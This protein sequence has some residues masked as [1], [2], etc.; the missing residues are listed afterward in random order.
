M[1]TLRFPF[2]LPPGREIQVGEISSSVDGLTFVLEKREPFYVFTIRGF[3]SED[4]AK[5]YINNV[6]AGLMWVLMHY[7]LWPQAIWELSKVVYADD[8]NQAAKNLGF[9]DPVDGLIDGNWPAVYPTEKRIRT[10]TAGKITSL[11]SYQGE[12]IV[13]L[14]REGLAFP[15][16]NA[17][18]TDQKLRIAFELYGAYFTE[19]SLNA[20]FL[21][22]IMALEALAIGIPRTPLVLDLLDKW[23]QEVAELQRWLDPECEDATSLEALSRELLYRKEDS[24]RRQIRNVV[25]ATLQANGDS[26]A[27][28]MGQLAI[29]L[30]DHRSTLVHD[31]KLES[32][33]LGQAASDAQKIVERVLRIRFIQ[34]A[35]PVGKNNTNNCGST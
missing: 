28:E 30:Y 5:S 29:K 21:S 13:R 2:Q 4:R 20:K 24:I 6:W 35:A 22:L 27:Y 10:I 34:K 26:D 25:L 12:N 9:N 7:G 17:V 18:I 19:F 8:P 23:K 14:F 15:K 32:A 31:G 16:S 1:Y 11:Q 3:P 33:V